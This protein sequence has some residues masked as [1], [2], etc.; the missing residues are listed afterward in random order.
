VAACVSTEPAQVDPGTAA[1]P[2]GLASCGGGCVDVELDPAHCG[3]CDKTCAE[4]LVCSLGTCSTECLGGTT[5]C[6]FR[7]IDTRLDPQNCG[8]CAAACPEG[9]VCSGGKCGLACAGGATNCSGKCIDTTLDPQNCGD[10]GK[11]CEPSLVCTGGGCAVA[12]KGGTVKCA[13]KCVDTGVD[14]GNCGDC[15]QI[16]GAGEVCSQ[17]I[18]ALKCAGGATKCGGLCVDTNLDPFHCGGCGLVCQPGQVCTSGTCALQCVGGTTKC[19][20]KCV[21]AEKDPAH[22][23]SCFNACPSGEV[24]S[25]G[26]CGL[27]CVGGTSKCG[28]KCVDLAADAANCGMCANAC[29]SG[30]VCSASACSLTCAAGATKCGQKCVDLASDAAN[31]GMC[32][33]ACAAGQACFASACVGTVCQPGTTE[34]CYTGPMGTLG[35]GICKAGTKICNTTGTAYGACEGEVTPAAM[36]T[37]CDGDENCDG[38]LPTCTK[39]CKEILAGNAAAPS[40]VY[41]LDPDGVGGGAPFKSYCDM[42]TESGGWTLLMKAA[43]TTYEFGSTHWTSTSTDNAASL[44]ESFVS[45]KFESFNTVLVSQLLIKAQSGNFTRL[46]LPATKTVLQFFQGSTALLTYLGGSPTPGNLINGKNWSYCGAIWRINTHYAGSGAKIRLGG[47]VTYFWSCG[48]GADA[49]G[50]PTGAHLLGF[51]IVDDNWGPFQ[52]NKKSFGIRDAHDSDHLAPGQ[53]ASAALLYGR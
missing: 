4:G 16:C 21:D 33:N 5:L 34:L 18:C 22:C 1:C 38:V 37:T 29:Q 51:G 53:L 32:G 26:I 44:D 42:A 30:E 43:E 49:A 3:A 15:D 13:G 14:P 23:G 50:E 12:C 8:A 2:A 36:D 39:S 24:C 7:C 27:S 45:A 19:A 6:D 25:A 9:Q 10:C 46:G 48:Y 52:F 20:D 31:C 40:G 35:V 41:T 17:G 11:A 47:W 28:T